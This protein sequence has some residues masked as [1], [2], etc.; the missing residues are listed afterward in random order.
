MPPTFKTEGTKRFVPQIT[1]DPDAEVSREEVA[2]DKWNFLCRLRKTIPHYVTLRPTTGIL[3]PH[4]IWV[5]LPGRRTPVRCVAKT[6]A[7]QA[8]AQKRKKNES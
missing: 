8:S 1:R 3:K 7:G 6:T 5:G 2:Q 4:S